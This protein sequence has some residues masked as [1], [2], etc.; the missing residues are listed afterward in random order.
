M[1]LPLFDASF[2]EVQANLYGT[3]ISDESILPQLVTMR[4]VHVSATL[5]EVEQPPSSTENMVATFL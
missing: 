3:N 1:A 4:E 2:T 5:K